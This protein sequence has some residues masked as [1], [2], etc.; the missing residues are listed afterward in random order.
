MELDLSKEEQVIVS[1]ILRK[2]LPRATV[3]VFGSRAEGTSLPISDL[4]LLILDA[5]PLSLETVADLRLAFSA[6]FLPFQVDLVDGHSVT[7]EF[8]DTISLSRK[9]IQKAQP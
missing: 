2:H 6:S 9:L 8:L 5:K 3:W 1:E 4:D 7:K